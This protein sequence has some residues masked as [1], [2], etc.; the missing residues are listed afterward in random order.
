MCSGI[1][2]AYSVNFFTKSAVAGGFAELALLHCYVLLPPDAYFA[3]LIIILL[4]VIGLS[5][6]A[7]FIVGEVTSG[8]SRWII[9]TSSAE[10]LSL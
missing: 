6:L 2:S 5:V 9:F 7:F 10:L 8:S 1:L 3:L 4:D